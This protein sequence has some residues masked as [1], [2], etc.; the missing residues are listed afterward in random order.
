MTSTFDSLSPKLKTS[1]EGVLNQIH[2][3]ITT[4]VAGC[5][6]GVTPMKG[7]P[8][9]ALGHR[10]T[11]VEEGLFNIRFAWTT[12]VPRTAGRLGPTLSISALELTPKLRDKGLVGELLRRLERD[13][14][15]ENIMFEYVYN[16]KF[17]QYLERQGYQPLDWKAPFEDFLWKRIRS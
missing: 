17:A 13:Q 5:V 8:Y 10:V 2:F 15:F 14:G 12:G 16:E 9:L 1:V 7:L 4:A 11:L 3:A 6:G